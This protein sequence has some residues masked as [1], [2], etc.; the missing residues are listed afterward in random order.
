[1]PIPRVPWRLG[2]TSYVVE[3]DL[4]GNAHYLAQYCSASDNLRIQEMQLV[5]FD[6]PNGPSNLPDARVVDELAR[7]QRDSGLGYTVHLLSDIA[8]MDG[9][10]EWQR[11]LSQA[12]DVITRTRALNPIYVLHVDGHL[13]RQEATLPQ[14]WLAGMVRSLAQVAGWAGDGLR[15]A[16]ENLEGYAPDFVVDTVEIA[17]VGRCLDVGHLWLDGVDP[18]PWLVQAAPRLRV[19]HL[20]GVE[21]LADGN[22][23]DHVALA[24][25]APDA[26]DEVVAHLWRM[27]FAGV[28]TLEVFGQEDFLGSVEALA[29][30]IRRVAQSIQ[31]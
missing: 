28:L 19:V 25:A 12:Q 16:V 3:D 1:M 17:N 18:L 14:E 8:P 15:L 2:A 10:I 24:H 23:R 20:H 9:P 7:I 6:L 21:S 13:W 27:H 31:E 11:P 30:S 5:L 22:R 4:V 26:L 29:A